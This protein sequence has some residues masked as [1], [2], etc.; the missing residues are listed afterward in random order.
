MTVPPYIMNEDSCKLREIRIPCRIGI[1]PW[2]ETA[3]QVV[4]VDLRYPMAAAAAAQSDDIRATVD[5]RA[6][7]DGVF[8]A[9]EG[10]RFKLLETLAESVAQWVLAHTPVAWVE[11]DATKPLTGTA[12]QTATLHIRRERT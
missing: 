8:H 2:E 4:V 3:T 10:G 6:V 12:A 1:D 7:G 5:Y 11:V 9:H